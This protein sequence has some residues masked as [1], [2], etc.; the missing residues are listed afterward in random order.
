MRE[1][2]DWE[3]RLL[4]TLDAP[5]PLVARPFAEVA[6]RADVSEA[7]VLERVR[8]WVQDGTIRRFGARVNHRSLGYVTNGM[9]VWRVPAEQVEHAGRFM[10]SLPEV[11]HCYVRP[12][13]PGWDYNLYAMIHG[14]SNEAVLAVAGR[15]AQETGLEQYEVL[16]STREF[17][18]SAPR[19]FAGNTVGSGDQTA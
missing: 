1:F 2:E 19:Y 8:S 15:I 14:A 6:G 12:P 18:K 17:K 7:E 4:G 10:A 5:L 13:R 9:S 16:F 11:S 3:I